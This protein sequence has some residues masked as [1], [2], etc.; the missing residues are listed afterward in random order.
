MTVAAVIVAGGSG[1][2]AGGEK[3]K[4]YQLIGGRPVIWWTLKAFLGHPAITHVQPVIGEGHEALFA[5]SVKGLDIAPAVIGGT[6]R[7]DSC[8]IGVEAVG[9]HGPGKVLIHDAARPFVSDGLIDDVISWLDRFP[10]VIPGM[11]VAETLKFAP[12]GVVSR[13]VDRAGIWAAQ[14]PQGFL[15]DSILAA[16]RK[17]EME[18]TQGLTDDAS[19]AE[20]AGIA[21]SM[22][23]GRV[24]NRKLTTHEDIVMADKD[25]MARQLAHLPDIRVGQGIDIHPFDEGNA[26]I[27]CGVEIPYAKKLQGHSD[28]DAA[29]HA[30][31]D[32]I[33]GTIGEGDIGTH[34][35]PSDPQWKGAPSKIF[36]R[37][38]MELLTARGGIVANADI[39]ILAEAPK[40]SPHV[41]Q[42]KAVLSALL[43]V[44]ADRVAVKATTTEKLGAI[45]RKEGIMAFATVTVRLP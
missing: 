32:A 29:M 15:Y 18:R 1:L 13:T 44:T 5:D 24:E 8:R 31:T 45:G 23:T 38:A 39:T 36:L 43:D 27:L 34:F 30:L 35:P 9:R 28:A 2:R 10:A 37:K 25:M 3:P 41:A 4:Q 17:A 12:G 7:Q 33:L 14:T 26:V 42:M 20:H 40:I 16:Y 22:I 11:P 21:I 6:T 19:V